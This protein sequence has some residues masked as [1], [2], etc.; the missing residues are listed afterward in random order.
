[1]IKIKFRSETKSNFLIILI[2]AVVILWAF[3]GFTNLIDEPFI[4]DRE[5]NWQIFLSI[6]M[7]GLVV[8]AIIFLPE[9]IRE[10]IISF[11]NWKKEHYR[12]GVLEI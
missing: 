2:F 7:A 1:M 9:I 3:T 5:L 6:S 8:L 4:I 12:D 11:R 10:S